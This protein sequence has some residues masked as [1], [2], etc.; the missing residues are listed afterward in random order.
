MSLAAEY[1]AKVN[2]SG[3][4]EKYRKAEASLWLRFAQKA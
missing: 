4:P 2:N 1:K 3:R